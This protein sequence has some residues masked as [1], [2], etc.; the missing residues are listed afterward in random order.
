MRDTEW[1]IVRSFQ[2]F[3]FWS[4]M[5]NGAAGHT[6]RGGWDHADELRDRARRG[7]RVHALVAGDAPSRLRRTWSRQALLEQYPSVAVSN[8]TLNGSNLIAPRLLKPHQDWYDEDRAWSSQGG[9]YD[10]PLMQRASRG[11]F[12]SC[13]FLAATP[14]TGTLPRFADLEPDTTYR[15]YYYDPTLGRR[16]DLGTLVRPVPEGIPFV[17]RFVQGGSAAWRDFGVSNLAQRR[18]PLGWKEPADN[19]RQS[20]DPDA[21]ASVDANSDA[22]A[23]SCSGFTTRTITRRTLHPGA[24]R[25]LSA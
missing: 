11:K 23:A 18:S 24:P 22:E 20:S 5:L 9:R 10:L 17:D 16:F 2:R 3:M 13:S 14:T 21:E 19:G 4:S 6:V 1:S 25:H 8:L 12:D 7:V 15:A